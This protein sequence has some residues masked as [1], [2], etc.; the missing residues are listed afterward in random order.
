MPQTSLPSRDLRLQLQ[1]IMHQRLELSKRRGRTPRRLAAAARRG[2]DEAGE[3]Y[4]IC[5]FRFRE[6][7]IMPQTSLPSRDLRLQLQHI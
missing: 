5:G 7:H 2:G 3:W 6:E 1:H 4:S